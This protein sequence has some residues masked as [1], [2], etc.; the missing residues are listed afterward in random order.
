M[1]GLWQT[2][3]PDPAKALEE[4]LP[5]IFQELIPS[6][7]S[8]LWRVREASCMG[9]ANLLGGKRFAQVE[10]NLVEVYRMSLRAM[11]DVKETVRKAGLALNRAVAGMCLRLC[12]PSQSGP[13]VANQGPGAGAAAAPRRGHLTA[14][15]GSSRC[16]YRAAGQDCAPCGRCDSAVHF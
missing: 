7:G 6:C 16:R 10:G 8:R 15:R 3:A 12:D 11:D 9:L 2:V 13:E 4:Y 5:N 1:A 14:G